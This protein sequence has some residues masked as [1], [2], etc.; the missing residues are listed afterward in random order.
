[1]FLYAYSRKLHL[2]FVHETIQ[3]T[4]NLSFIHFK[5]SLFPHNFITF[6]YCVSMYLNSLYP[7]KNEIYSILLYVSYFLFYL[8]NDI[9]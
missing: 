6:I 3:V 4:R 2:V 8:V 9:E 1:M 5:R 7:L